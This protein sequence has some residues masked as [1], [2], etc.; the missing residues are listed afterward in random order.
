MRG[1]RSTS[2]PS[3][4]RALC[5]RTAHTSSDA[6][7]DADPGDVVAAAQGAPDVQRRLRS[8]GDPDQPVALAERARVDRGHHPHH[9]AAVQVAV[10]ARDGLLRDVQRRGDP[11]KR[12]PRVE[13]QRAEDLPVEG[14]RA[15][16]SA[17]A[18]PS[19]RKSTPG[20]RSGPVLSV[21]RK[22]LGARTTR[23]G[24]RHAQVVAAVHGVSGHVHAARGRHDRERR[25]AGHGSRPQD[26]LRFAAVGGGRLRARARRAR[27]RHGVDR[28]PDRTPPRLRRRAGVVRCRLLRLRHRAELG[29]AHRRSRGAGRRC[30][31]DVRDDVRVAEQQLPGPRSRHGL[32]HVGRGQR[33]L[34]SG[35]ADRRRSAHRRHL[36]AVDLLR[37]SSGQ[38]AR[39]R[40]VHHCAR[41]H[42]RA[43]ALADRP[44]RHGELHRR[45]RHAHLRFDQGQRGRL[46]GSGV[47]G[48]PA[49]ARPYCS[50]SS[51]SSSGPVPRRCST[52]NC[53]AIAASPAC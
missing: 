53:C 39:D 49:R 32:R 50:R 15:T 11:T 24:H 1:R 4:S 6:G 18:R 20:R 25:A 47:V 42:A 43:G 10:P 34:G 8:R 23:E 36:L 28:R 27:S 45:R 5:E 51:C 17:V 40:L 13:L 2:S 46:G 19:W 21:V 37:Q 14:I 41:R 35:R 26:R 22:R 7:P 29:R 30:G 9:A 16:E 33:R 12:R 44:A 52:S 38:R 31:G 3:R 48:L